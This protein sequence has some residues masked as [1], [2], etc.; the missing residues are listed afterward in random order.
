V[1][2]I[3]LLRE[4]IASWYGRVFAEQVRILYGGSVTPDSIAGFIKEEQ[5][6]GV[7]LGGASLKL[8]SFIEVVLTAADVKRRI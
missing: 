5:I 8:G 1:A 7:L 6:D 3:R 4:K 2:V